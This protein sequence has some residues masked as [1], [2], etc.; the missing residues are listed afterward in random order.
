MFN[1]DNARILHRLSSTK[2]IS[3]IREYR[4]V[5]ILFI[6]LA[7]STKIFEKIAVFIAK[8]IYG[9]LDG[10]VFPD[11]L[12]DAKIVTVHK[13]KAKDNINKY[14]P[15]S[16]LSFFSKIFETVMYEALAWFS[17]CE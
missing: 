4:Q 14:R 16:I 6:N 10:A 1:I 8:P 17:H 15:V 12:M 9:K 13:R 7:I 2:R 11:V 5:S 3:T